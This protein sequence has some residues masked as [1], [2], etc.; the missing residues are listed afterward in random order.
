M[1]ALKICF[2]CFEKIS[3][4]RESHSISLLTPSFLTRFRTSALAVLRQCLPSS[5]SA[6]VAVVLSITVFNPKSSF[7]L[8]LSYMM[9]HLISGGI[10][11]LSPS[12]ILLTSQ[13]NQ[14]M[15]DEVLLM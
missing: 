10:P 11:L 13:Y 12:L 2:G 9:A 7:S 5:S 6:C 8:S 4:K 14:G 1:T 3:L 15:S